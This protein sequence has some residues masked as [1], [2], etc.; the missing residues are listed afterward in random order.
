MSDRPRF[1]RGR[2]VPIR[3]KKTGPHKGLMALG[4]GLQVGSGAVGWIKP[5]IVTRRFAVAVGIGA[6]AADWIGHAAMGASVLKMKGATNK[7]KAL[8]F[9]KHQA[10]AFGLGWGLFSAG[11]AKNRKQIKEAFDGALRS[12]K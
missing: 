4:Y 11:V 3:E 8:T 6:Y 7:E 12:K 2:I 9:A 10:I 1:I 5:K